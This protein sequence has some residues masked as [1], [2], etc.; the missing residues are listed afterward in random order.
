MAACMARMVVSKAI[1]TE[2]R[3]SMSMPQLRKVG[4]REST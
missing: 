3:V 1:I 2:L 4:N